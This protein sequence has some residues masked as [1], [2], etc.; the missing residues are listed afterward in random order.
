VHG[1]RTWRLLETA[2]RRTQATRL[3]DALDRWIPV[4]RRGNPPEI[5]A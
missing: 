4:E 1:P 3:A 2:L 5:T